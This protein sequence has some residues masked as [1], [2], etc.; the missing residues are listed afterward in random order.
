M[1]F[2]L[3][4][5]VVENDRG[6]VVREFMKDTDAITMYKSSRECLVYL[7]HLDYVDTETIMRE[8]LDA[9]VRGKKKRLT[10]FWFEFLILSFLFLLFFFFLAGAR[11]IILVEGTQHVVLGDWF[12][13]WSNVG[14]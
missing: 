3:I 7:T 13:Q 2:C 11:T 14:G 1:L 6:E 4:V 9:Q 12:D 5:L 10:F 8:R